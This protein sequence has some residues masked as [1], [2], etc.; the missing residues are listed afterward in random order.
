M[1]WYTQIAIRGRLG[2]DSLVDLF[3]KK[4][5]RHEEETRSG[6]LTA[7]SDAITTY[8]NYEFWKVFQ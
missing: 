1:A 2:K 7:L 8:L 4:E 3:T 5:L 6:Y